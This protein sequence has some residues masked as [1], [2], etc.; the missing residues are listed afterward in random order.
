MNTTAA[1]YKIVASKTA[2]RGGHIIIANVPGH[3]PFVTWYMRD[4][5]NCFHGHYFFNRS[6]AEHDFTKRA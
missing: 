1:G 2:A 3:H 5:G 4:D 6:E